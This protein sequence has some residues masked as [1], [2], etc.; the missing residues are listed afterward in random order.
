MKLTTAYKSDCDLLSLLLRL[1]IRER[2]RFVH[3]YLHPTQQK[4]LTEHVARLLHN[5]PS[6]IVKNPE[7]CKSI[8]GVLKPHKLVIGKFIKKARSKK[9]KKPFTLSQQKGGALFSLII[10]G[11]LPLLAGTVSSEQKYFFAFFN[12]K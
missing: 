1:P 5:S 11:L 10:G 3:K 6:H 2:S 7:F 9:L 4:R 12:K 8:Q